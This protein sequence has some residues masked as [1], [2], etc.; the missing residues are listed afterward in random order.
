VLVVVA[1]AGLLYL[2]LQ[3][4]VGGSPPLCGAAGCGNVV[5]MRKLIESGRADVEEH[6]GNNRTALHYSA[7]YGQRD[8]A[9]LLIEKGANVNAADRYGE[10]P[11]HAAAYYGKIDVIEILLANGAELNALDHRGGQTPLDHAEN[12]IRWLAEERAERKSQHKEDAQADA[13]ET[14]TCNEVVKFLISKGA[15]RSSALK[16]RP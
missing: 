15:K 16:D 3:P 2:L 10:T 6:D 4:A 1:I 5:E 8:A 12:R 7:Y 14:R 9:R 13:I 11:L